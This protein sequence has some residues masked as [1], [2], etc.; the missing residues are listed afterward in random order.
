MSGRGGGGSRILGILFFVGVLVVVNV[1][2]MAFDWG[3]IL[4]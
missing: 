3:F 2:S 1:L 4:Y